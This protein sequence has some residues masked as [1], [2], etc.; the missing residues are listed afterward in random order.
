VSV[1]RPIP[2]PKSSISRNSS[3]VESKKNRYAP[4]NT[5]ANRRIENRNESKK[6]KPREIGI[7]NKDVNI[8][9]KFNLLTRL[10]FPAESIR[11]L[12]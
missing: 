10:I 9:S 12:V 2:M 7:A 1:P 11:G 5:F 3:L 6:P 8:I 4:L